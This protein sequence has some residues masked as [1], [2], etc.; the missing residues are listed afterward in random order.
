MNYLWLIPYYV[1]WHYTYAIVEL[2]NN[3]KNFIWFIWNFFSIPLLFRTL[4]RPFQRIKERYKLNDGPKVVLESITVNIISR[5]VGFVIRSF[6]IVAGVSA[7]I[8]I[9]ILGV[10]VFILW[11]F[12]PLILGFIFISGLR[13]III[14]SV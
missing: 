1:S 12:L 9:F 3:F 13:A 11:L 8:A 10:L 2:V 6:M 7:S 4:F 5:V 14:H